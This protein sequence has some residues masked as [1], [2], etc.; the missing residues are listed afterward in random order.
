MSNWGT[1]CNLHKD[2]PE[3]ERVWKNPQPAYIIYFKKV[4]KKPK[5]D[6]F[7]LDMVYNHKRR[8]QLI[9]LTH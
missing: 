7:D 6:Y 1:I 3:I 2:L 5:V 9:A 8:E 4:G